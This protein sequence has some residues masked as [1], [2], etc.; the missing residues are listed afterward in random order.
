MLEQV[1]LQILALS[2]DKNKNMKHS[3]QKGFTLI[4]LMIVVAI[5]GILAS[6]A[7]PAYQDYTARAKLSEV[8]LVA[9]S[10]RTIITEAAQVGLP[11]APAD[12]GFDCGED[13]GASKSQYVSALTT[14]ATGQIKVTIQQVTAAANGKIVSLTPYSDAALAV[15]SVAADFT[16]GTNQ[17]ISG[18]KC[19]FNGPLRYMPATCRAVS[20]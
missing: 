10:C 18:W 2:K 1:L 6:V 14:T 11:S 7:L 8:L 16:A 9:S 4:E 19:S 15:A 5:I 13:A 17:P 20:T 12:N 3:L